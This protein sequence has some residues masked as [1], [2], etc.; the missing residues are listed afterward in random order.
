LKFDVRKTSIKWRL[1]IY[2]AIFTAVVIVF[3]WVF[4]I[5]FLDDFY[6]TIKIGEIRSTAEEIGLSVD[7]SDLQEQVDSIS[8]RGDMSILVWNMDTGETISTP[9]YP[10]N[11]LSG[12]P[13][14]VKTDLYTK[15]EENGGEYLQ[16]FFRNEGLQPSDS[17]TD[18]GAAAADAQQN[19][20]DTFD[21]LQD[22]GRSG[23]MDTHLESM[24]DAKIV[25]NAGGETVLVLLSTTISPVNA[26]VQTLRTQLVIITAI[27][28]ALAVGIAFIISK[29]ISKPIVKINESAKVLASGNY[30]VRFEENGYREIGELART[31]NYA[32]K[33]LS[34]VEGLRRELIANISHDLRTPLTLIAGY[35]E[36]MRDIP[37]EYSPE[38]VQIIIDEAK[39][40]SNIVTDVLDLSRLQSGTQELKRE[41]LNLTRTLKDIVGRHVKLTAQQG[42]SIEFSYDEEVYVFAD[43]LRISQVV[44]NLL[45]NAINYT[46][47]DKKVWVRQSVR[48]GVV[49]VEF[50][51][52]GEGIPADKLPYIWD[53]YY[54]VDKSHKRAKVGSGLGL[55][56]VKAALDLHGAKYGASSV[57]GKGSIF[58]FELETVK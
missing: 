19:T 13:D 51:D 53:R 31:L 41:R 45:S 2:F 43:E 55:S 8:Q 38:N 56:I 9:D 1:F 7:D 28:V 20:Q 42:Y 12:L 15:A 16:R 6:K 3:L 50:E 10:G 22:G 25:Q 47:K 4:Q 18:P 49:R 39:R 54:K 21:F 35:S 24:I 37:G 34:T 29:V 11:V 30:D 26:T 5:V 32:A 33:E 57:E 58:W 48:E 46:G 27:M 52:T 40:L 36:V 44:Y 14:S 23:G 17:G